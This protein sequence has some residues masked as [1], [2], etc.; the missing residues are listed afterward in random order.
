MIEA[1][2]MVVSFLLNYRIEINYGVE[3][4]MLQKFLYGPIDDR[5]IKI[6]LRE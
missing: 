3:L 2:V 4:K 6:I 1:K 5:L